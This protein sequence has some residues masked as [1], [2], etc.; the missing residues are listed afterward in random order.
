MGQ[1]VSS[2]SRLRISFKCSVKERI[3]VSAALTCASAAI[4][5]KDVPSLGCFGGPLSGIQG[6]VLLCLEWN[7]RRVM[8]EVNRGLVFRE[9]CC[10]DLCAADFCFVIM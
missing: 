3:L 6:I 2:A 7:A 4:A 1:T 8:S 5:T 10:A 9:N